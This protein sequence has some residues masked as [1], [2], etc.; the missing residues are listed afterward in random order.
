MISQLALG[1]IEEMASQGIVLTPEE[2]VRLNAFGLRVESAKN[3]DAV[4][5][6]PRCV[7]LGGRIFREPTVQVLLWMKEVAG[8]LASNEESWNAMLLFACAHADEPGFFDRAE[9]REAAT[10]EREVE[11]LLRSLPAT[12]SQ[13]LAALVYLRFGDAPDSGEAPP[14]GVKLHDVGDVL[15]SDLAEAAGL[16][17]ISLAELKTLVRRGLRQTLESA[18]ISQGKRFS[19]SGVTELGDYIRVK[20]EIVE[21]H[22]KT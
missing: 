22:R 7:E 11:G 8:R 2:V 3:P 14:E 19:H 5:N 10:I 16:T 13:V 1:D 17:G 15:Y 18:Y 12:Q 20:R 9:M 4:V 6:A 21:R